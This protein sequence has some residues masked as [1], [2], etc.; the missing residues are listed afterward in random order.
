MALTIHVVHN[1]PGA[2]LDQANY[3]QVCTYTGNNNFLNDRDGKM[4]P[5]ERWMPNLGMLRCKSTLLLRIDG[6]HIY[7]SMSINLMST[8][9]AHFSLPWIQYSSYINPLK[10]YTVYIQAIL[11]FVPLYIQYPLSGSPSFSFPCLWAQPIHLLHQ[12]LCI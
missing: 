6:I 10:I 1:S 5:C 4:L 2:R 12:S 8:S 11:P 9:I 3:D 7:P